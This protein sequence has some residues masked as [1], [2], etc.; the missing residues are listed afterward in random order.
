MNFFILFFLLFSSTTLASVNI[1]G[2]KQVEGTKIIQSKGEKI[3]IG[4]K[5]KISFNAKI[6]LATSPKE[7]PPDPIS[8][9]IIVPSG[10]S[11]ELFR[12]ENEIND[13]LVIPH[14]FSH[15]R[16]ANGTYLGMGWLN[17]EQLSGQN[18][19]IIKPTPSKQ[20]RGNVLKITQKQEPEKINLQKLSKRFNE[21]SK[22]EWTYYWRDSLLGDDYKIFGAYINF[23][24]STDA[25]LKSCKF[26][27]Q[28][29][30]N[31]LETFFVFDDFMGINDRVS[32]PVRFD[33]LEKT[34]FTGTYSTDG[35]GIFI[36]SI[37]FVEGLLDSE[38]MV[39]RVRPYLGNSKEIVF[40]TSDLIKFWGN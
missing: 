2:M 3:R 7:F 14:Y 12:I 24:Y 29:G 33:S 25:N 21:L 36:S 35:K 20:T 6:I 31:G 34:N 22:G 30:E 16:D 27:I 8:D 19:L 26:H 13:N 17:A 5:L 39:I 18:Y 23:F 1:N 37:R 10:G 28:V 9:T 38:K 40:L 11:L 32:V 4:D 15:A